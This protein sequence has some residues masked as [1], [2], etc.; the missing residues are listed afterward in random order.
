[1]KSTTF[2]RN[3]FYLICLLLV[4]PFFSI[5]NAFSQSYPEQNEGWTLSVQTYTFRMHTFE[6]AVN[7]A[8]KANLKTVEAYF[9]QNISSQTDEV[10]SPNLSDNGKKLVRQFLERNDINIVAFGVVGAN[11]E[12]E[13][14]RLFKFAE[15]MKVSILNVEPKEHFLPLIGKLAS[16]YKI[17]VAI[18]NHPEPTH[19]W[20][21]DIVLSAIRKADSPYVGAC[22]DIGHWI[23]SGLDPIASLK[24]YEGKLFALHMKDL[25]KKGKD[26]H[27][28]HWGTGVANISS[29][30]S[31]LRRQNFKGNISCEYEYNWDNNV[32][33]VISSISNFRDMMNK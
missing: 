25:N 33:D 4:M 22:A 2:D 1:M 27:D 9:G 15:E 8:Q 11:D 7:F 24:M 14:E 26:A 30:I 21:P 32:D 18:H 31:E 29:V 13:W 19:Y 6:D 12:L 5:N 3:Y 28:V 17:K 16:K 20:N 10:M 23:R